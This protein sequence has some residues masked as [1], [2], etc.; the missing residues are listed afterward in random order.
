M[1]G[2]RRERRKLRCRSARWQGQIVNCSDFQL[3]LT[4]TK[5]LCF[6]QHSRIK[7]L[8]TFVFINIPGSFASFPQRSFVFNNIPGSFLQKRIP[9]KLQHA[10]EI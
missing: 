3:P 2:S 7:W 5:R 6:L 8:T 4:S 1:R 10:I 9:S